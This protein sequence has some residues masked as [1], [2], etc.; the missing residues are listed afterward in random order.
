MPFAHGES[1]PRTTGQANARL[2]RACAILPPSEYAAQR[3][4]FFGS[5]RATLNHI[6]LVDRFYIGA[7][8]GPP[9]RPR[10]AGRGARLPDLPTLVQWQTRSTS[11]CSRMCWP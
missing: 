2:H 6:L 9:L 3:P 4:S 10:R 11:A 5:I 8:E 1:W 7:L